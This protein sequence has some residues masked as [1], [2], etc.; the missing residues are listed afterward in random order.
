MR[1][2]ERPRDPPEG[3]ANKGTHRTSGPPAI[4]RTG[5][6]GCFMFLAPAA[7]DSTRRFEAKST[8]VNTFEW[9]RSSQPRSGPD[10]AD[11]TLS[12]F[13]RE[14]NV[15]KFRSGKRARPGPADHNMAAKPRRNAGCGNP[16][17]HSACQTN[18]LV[19]KQA[20]CHNR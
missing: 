1:T 2:G 6:A 13:V 12:T 3:E 4:N 5:S 11:L 17:A 20:N 16:G 9:L 19:K 8:K 7:L 15:D 10:R 14:K 18:C